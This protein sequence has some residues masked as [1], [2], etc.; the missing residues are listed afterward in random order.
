MTGAVRNEK[1]YMELCCREC[2]EWKNTWKFDP[3][4]VFRRPFDAPEIAVALSWD[5]KTPLCLECSGESWEEGQ[6]EE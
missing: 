3:T 5:F 6:A 1:G 4:S 2:G